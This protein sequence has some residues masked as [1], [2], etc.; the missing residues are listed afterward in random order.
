MF[1]CFYDIAF[2]T[3]K[4]FGLILETRN[5]MISIGADGVK[6]TDKESF[7]LN[8]NHADKYVGFAKQICSKGAVAK[9]F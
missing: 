4:G 2:H 8:D 6:L 5:Y 9:R 1:D 7:H 3:T